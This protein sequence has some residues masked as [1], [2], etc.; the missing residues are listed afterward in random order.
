[1]EGSKKRVISVIVVGVLAAGLTGMAAYSQKQNPLKY[2]EYMPTQCIFAQ[3]TLAVGDSPGFSSYFE[4][5]TKLVLQRGLLTVEYPTFADDV[6]ENALYRVNPDVQE[7]TDRLD[8]F[9]FEFPADE[10]VLYDVSD[11]E[12]LRYK[13]IVGEDVV[14]LIR[15]M[16][17]FPEAGELRKNFIATLTEYMLPEHVYTN[18]EPYT[19]PVTTK[20]A[21]WK[22]LKTHED[23]EKVCQIPEDVLEDM[24]TRA[25]L[26]TVIYYPL[27]KDFEVDDNR[28]VSCKY[29]Y[30]TFNG[31]RELAARDDFDWECRRKIHE[32]ESN[33][34]D[35]SD[36]MRYRYVCLTYFHMFAP[37]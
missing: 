3:E 13:M 34:N 15:P 5:D 11:G 29:V 27:V 8:E 22:D 33:Y 1:M 7:L 19:Y 23:K 24:T 10:P 31:L 12:K 26:E 17:R 32:I 28:E 16:G 21:E 37:R 9:G 2:G 25:L 6:C 14:W 36:E 4:E 35:L 20:S 30:D 18:D